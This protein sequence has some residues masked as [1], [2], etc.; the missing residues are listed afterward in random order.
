MIKKTQGLKIKGC[1]A[2][3]NK[4]EE[5]QILYNII[6]CGIWKIKQNSNYKTIKK[7]NRFT[8]IEKKLVV[9]SG[10]KEGGGT[11]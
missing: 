10:Q 9:T 2:K 7:R 4:S 8:D 5:K 1:Y 11:R 6:I 3:G